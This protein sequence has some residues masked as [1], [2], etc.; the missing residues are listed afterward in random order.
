MKP[1]DLKL[2][3]MV[4]SL[5]PTAGELGEGMCRQMQ[6]IAAQIVESYMTPCRK[7]GYEVGDNFR[8]TH[9]KAVDVGFEYN[10]II[11][12]YEDDGSDFPLFRGNNSRYNH[13]NGKGGAYLHLDFV[14]KVN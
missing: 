9:K 6:D 13:C 7:L 12:L 8:V 3:E 11:T 2:A 14:E 4:M 5:N 1:T 10:Q